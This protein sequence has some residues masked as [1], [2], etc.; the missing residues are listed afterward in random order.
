MICLACELQSQ[1]E[2]EDRAGGFGLKKAFFVFGILQTYTEVKIAASMV[3]KQD[4]FKNP[5]FLFKTKKKKS[6]LY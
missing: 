4:R 3:E 2:D 6:Q 5:N 1:Q